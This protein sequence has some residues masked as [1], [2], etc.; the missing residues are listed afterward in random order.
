MLPQVSLMKTPSRYTHE[1]SIC[2]PATLV[3]SCNTRVHQ[4]A[5]HRECS[6]PTQRTKEVLDATPNAPALLLAFPVGVLS[7]VTSTSAVPV[8]VTFDVIHLL[9]SR[10]NRPGLLTI[11]LRPA[12]HKFAFTASGSGDRLH[13]AVQCI[14]S[15]LCH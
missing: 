1:A 7:L 8:Q 5:S 13:D 4:K 2:L 9:V 15:Q 10:R 6:S 12:L 3:I 11:V 14:A